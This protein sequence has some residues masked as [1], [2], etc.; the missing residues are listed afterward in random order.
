MR[1]DNGNLGASRG[2]AARARDADHPCD[3]RSIEHRR[4]DA[5]SHRGG[6]D[7]ARENRRRATR[8]R[9]R[10]RE[11]RTLE[12]SVKNLCSG[13][14]ESRGAAYL[15]GILETL[16]DVAG[17]GADHDGA[18][19]DGLRGGRGRFGE[20]TR[21]AGGEGSRRRL[22]GSRSRPVEVKKGAAEAHL[23]G[24]GGASDARLGGGDARDGR[25]NAEGE[26][27]GGH[28]DVKCGGLTRSV[29]QA[30]GGPRRTIN[31]TA[32]PHRPLVG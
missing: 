4:S 29:R 26:H 19:L 16:G 20:S 5:R 3:A 7:A 22:G 32:N 31:S 15:E 21:A 10:R 11:R 18:S 24:D 6:W 12:A 13:A 27:G 9:R 8:S 30:V 2:R 23:R 14:G 25:D 17:G 1:S 28:F